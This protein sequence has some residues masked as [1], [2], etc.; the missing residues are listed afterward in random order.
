MNSSSPSSTSRRCA[1]VEEGPGHVHGD[2]APAR[3]APQLGEDRAVVRLVPGLD[4]PFRQALVLV[5]HHEVEV[6][7]DQ[8]AEAV[9]GGAGPE[10][11]VEG[12]EAGLRLHEDPAARD[13]LE[14][15]RDAPPAPARHH[16]DRAAAALLERDLERLDEA[17]A[18]PLTQRDPVDQ[19]Q[20]TRR[21]GG[22]RVVADLDHGLAHQ[23][24]VVAALDERR[25]GAPVERLRR[26]EAHEDP[27][28][29]RLP[30]EALGDTR[31]RVAPHLFPA[32]AADG[33]PRPREEQPEVVVDLGR[34]GHGRARAARQR[35][36]AD[37]DR[38][39]DAVHLVHPRLLHPLQELPRVRGEALDVAA[40]PLGVQGVEGQ[41][42]LPG[43]GDPGHD[44]QPARR[45]RHVDP[46]QVVDA[47]S[48][49]DDVG[50]HGNWKS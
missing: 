2:A 35:A 34:R 39:A 18:L 28:A 45:D 22:A 37:G 25:Q 20:G 13:A 47:D 27:R 1:L 49:Q 24:A 16:G 7:L 14:A 40:L 50:G 26:L 17:P 32:P 10:G 31:R 21:H 11:V 4:R 42:A 19:D 43:A 46:L 44:D 5:R 8:V 15:L 30:E 38:G 41:A 48:T 12:E 23:E 6:H 33:S 3:E 9:T 36:L 29:L